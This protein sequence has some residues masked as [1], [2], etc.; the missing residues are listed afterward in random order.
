MDCKATVCLGEY[1]RGG[2]SRGAT[3]ALDHDMGVKQ[4]RIP[5]GILNEDGGGL[6]LE[7]GCSYKTSDFMVDSLEACWSN[8]S[9]Q[10][11]AAIPFIQIKVDNGPESSGVRTQF[12]ARLVDWV[13]RIG[14]SIQLLYFPPYHSKYNPIERCWGGLE[15]HWNGAL[16]IDSDTMLAWA[17]SMTWKGKHPFVALNSSE[18]PKGIK[19]SKKQMRPIEARLIRNTELPKWDILIHPA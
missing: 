6:H 17:K 13:D 11:Q 8:L 9:P 2:L 19:L 15:L 10:E 7:F 18:Y 4:K 3:Q 1:S 16:L 5:C 14:K 12:L